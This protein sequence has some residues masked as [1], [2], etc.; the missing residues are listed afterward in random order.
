[1]RRY[2]IIGSG[3]AGVAA[4]ESIRQHD[5][6]GSI[7]LISAETQ[8]Y[9]SRPGLA[10]YLTGEIPEDG[11]YPFS[12]DDFKRLNLQ[13]IFGFVRAVQ[14]QEH[15]ILLKDGQSIPYDRLLI[16]TGARAARMQVPGI[17]MEGVFKLD[18]LADAR[19]ILHRT[20]RA[21]S[22]VVVGGGIT[23]LELVEGLIARKVRTHYFLRGDRYWSNVLDEDESRIVEHRL[24]EEKVNIHYHTELAEIVGKRG[25]V[26]GVLTKGGEHIPC[27]MALIAIGIRPRIE[28]AQ[29]AG[30]E[31][32]RGIRVDEYLQSTQA[33]I[34]AAGDVAQV[35]DPLTGRSVIDS[36]WGPAREQ[37]RA[38][39]ANMAGVPTTYIKSIAFNV[40]R[41]AG[42]TTTIVGTVGRGQDEDL[43]GIARGDSET[44]R[45]L[46]DAIA[47]QTGFDVNRL[48][49]LLGEDRLLGAIV[50]GDQTLSRPIHQLVEHKADI[51]PIRD[52]LMASNA[53]L[54][55]ILIDFWT[56]WRRS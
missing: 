53:P 17:D 49:V 19:N 10:Y 30:L 13:R 1:M 8:G 34:Y 55:E 27:Q 42:L 36:L 6:H 20:R 38:A 11:L 7:I 18:N 33:D 15:R 14:P 54:S 56:Q 26:S 40:T 45:Q 37:G 43:H 31:T 29:A 35:F 2:V 39:G 24:M 32:D 48:R 44:W 22:A 47:A 5:P 46:P 51:R 25:K 23:A 16:A 4:A 50:M 12:K 21:R 9:Y 41:L 28:L 3:P 52:Q